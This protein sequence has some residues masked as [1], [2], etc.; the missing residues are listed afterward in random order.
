M[1]EPSVRITPGGR[2]VID[3][4]AWIVRRIRAPRP[5]LVADLHAWRDSLNPEDETVT[6]W[7]SVTQAWSTARGHGLREPGLIV[8]EQSRLDACLWVLFL[9]A[10]DG[11]Q[12]AVVGINDN[13]PA[14]YLTFRASAAVSGGFS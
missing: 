2:V 12:I 10:A 14:A 8:H 7:T 4:A 9:D 6:D 3:A 11:S 13:E 1:G 5:D